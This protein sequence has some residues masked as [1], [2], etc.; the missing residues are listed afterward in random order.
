MSGETYTV[1]RYWFVYKVSRS[2]EGG[3]NSLG[4]FT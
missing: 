1:H 4:G 2:E 3:E